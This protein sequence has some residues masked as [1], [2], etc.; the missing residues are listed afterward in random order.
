VEEGESLM[1]FAVYG[2]G[3]VGGYFGARLR[4]AGFEVGFVARGAH[5]EALRVNG[6]TLL[7][8]EGDVRIKTVEA[9]DDPGTLK[10]VD[11]ILLGVKAFQVR[12]AA[13]RLKGLL[14][15]ETFVVP[16]QNGVDAV[17]ELQEILGLGRV[18]PGLCRIST[19]V[20]EPGTIRHAAVSPVIEFGEPG[21]ATTPRL[22]ALTAAFQ[23]A[24]GLTLKV[25]SDIEQA[26]WEKFLFISPA[27]GVAAVART[28]IGVVRSVPE[29]R[30]LLKEALDETIAVGRAR[31]IA[32]GEDVA[33]KILSFL[34]SLAPGAVPSMARD[35]GLGRPSELD[36]QTGAVVRLGRESGVPVPVN[37]LLY[38]CLLP[39]ELD[40]RQKAG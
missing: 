10:P 39:A 3:G 23:K 13:S 21:G 31:K 16:L 27:S 28:S 38:A 2:A 22:E 12:E 6:L 33:E 19:F 14:G 8:P 15:P 1:R 32:F 20:E 26:I 30:A 35:V 29:T 17:P 25:R 40:A 5:L 7:S 18:V 9:T 11:C 36:Y 37:A 34:D 24:R 4:E